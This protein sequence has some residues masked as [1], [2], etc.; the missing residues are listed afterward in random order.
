MLTVFP[1]HFNSADPIES[2]VNL[3]VNF[4]L[5]SQGPTKEMTPFVPIE[6][7]EITENLS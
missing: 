2:V 1:N 5:T 7:G 4:A 3:I 6:T